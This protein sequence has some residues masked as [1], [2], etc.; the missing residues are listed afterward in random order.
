MKRYLCIWDKNR[1]DTENM[2][3][4]HYLDFF[5]EDKG[6]T[7][8]EIYVISNMDIGDVYSLPDYFDEHIVVRVKD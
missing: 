2:T 5:T 4:H 6:Y 3:E 8:E 1:F 7:Q